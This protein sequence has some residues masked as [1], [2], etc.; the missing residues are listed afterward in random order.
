MTP[1]LFISTWYFP[2]S[3]WGSK[4]GRHGPWEAHRPSVGLRPGRTGPHGPHAAISCRFTQVAH[5]C[6]CPASSGALRRPGSVAPSSWLQ[7]L[8]QAPHKEARQPPCCPPPAR[9]GPTPQ[10]RTTASV[11]SSRPGAVSARESRSHPVP[12]LGSHVGGPGM[13]RGLG[14]GTQASPAPECDLSACPRALGSPGSARGKEPACQFRRRK[15]CR[16]YPWIRK[17]PREG[18]GNS[19][20]YSSW[21]IPWTEEPGRLQPKGSQSPTRLSTLLYP[22]LKLQEL[23]RGQPSVGAPKVIAAA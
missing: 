15:R 7:A 20:Q 17:I 16:I 12:R 21:K 3:P 22:Q 1:K 8:R 10:A 23:G 11:P 13:V 4:G 5:G 18:N 14:Q 2:H 9:R 6:T 19:L